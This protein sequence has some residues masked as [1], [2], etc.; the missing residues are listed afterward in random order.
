VIA[1]RA[2]AHPLFAVRGRTRSASRRL[3][4]ARVRREFTPTLALS[5]LTP[6]AHPNAALD[7]ASS[8]GRRA[9]GVG[10]GHFEPR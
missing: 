8:S 5:C 3:A 4:G 2:V 9:E 7:L 10:G 6:H 1:P